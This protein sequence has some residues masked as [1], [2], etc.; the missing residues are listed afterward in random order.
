MTH[1]IIVAHTY[2]HHSLILIN[3]KNSLSL[4][5]FP[6]FQKKFIFQRRLSLNSPTPC[7]IILKSLTQE[8]YL[9]PTI[10]LKK[11]KFRK[12]SCS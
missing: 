3:S 12:I 2:T 8:T 10:F 5:H 7:L 6:L 1:M 11:N 4:S 9:N